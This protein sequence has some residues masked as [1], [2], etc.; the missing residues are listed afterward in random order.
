MVSIRFLKLKVVI[1]YDSGY[2][3]KNERCIVGQSE[4]SFSDAYAPHQLQQVVS[5]SVWL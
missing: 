3:V 2:T 1:I 5:L 4:K